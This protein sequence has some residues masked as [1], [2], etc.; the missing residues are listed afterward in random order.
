MKSGI[1][2]YTEPQE[3]MNVFQLGRRV[4]QVVDLLVERQEQI[5]VGLRGDERSALSAEIGAR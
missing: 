4:N 3:W 5:T 1:R 2:S